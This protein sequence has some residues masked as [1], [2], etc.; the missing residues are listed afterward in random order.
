MV[1]G[2]MI[3]AEE[4]REFQEKFEELVEAFHN[5]I[6]TQGQDVCFTNLS[7]IQENYVN[8][9]IYY[10][11]ANGRMVKIETMGAIDHRYRQALNIIG[12]TLWE[13]TQEAD[14]DRTLPLPGLSLPVYF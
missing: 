11:K 1:L 12:H 8:L 7:N 3:K 13:V 5:T 2:A 10:R 4:L 9:H 14:R 6:L